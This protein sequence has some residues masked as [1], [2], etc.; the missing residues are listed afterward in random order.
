MADNYLE[1]K[2]EEYQKK[3]AEYERLKKLGL[4]KKKNNSNSQASTKKAE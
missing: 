2:F 3:K 4:L 1:K